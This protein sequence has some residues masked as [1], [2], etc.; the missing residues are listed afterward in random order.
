MQTY[1]SARRVRFVLRGQVFL[2]IVRKGRTV[3][4]QKWKRPVQMVITAQAVVRRLRTA[5]QAITVPPLQLG[6]SVV[7]GPFVHREAL[8]QGVSKMGFIRSM[9][10]EIKRWRRQ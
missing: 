7:E 3:P 2:E 10:K 6:A 8:C 5:R 4:A 9:N 1:P